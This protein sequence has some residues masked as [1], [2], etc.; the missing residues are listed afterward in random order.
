VP[1][2]A[3]QSARLILNAALA[4]TALGL[5]VRASGALKEIVFAS[6]FGVSGD[7]D[8]FVLWAAQSEL[9]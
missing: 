6:A 4:L 2:A 1:V 8:A 5:V 9:R 7:T 3:A